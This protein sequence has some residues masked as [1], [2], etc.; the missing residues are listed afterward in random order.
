MNNKRSKN[1]PACLTGMMGL[2]M[3]AQASAVTLTVD[4]TSDANPTACTA[5]PGDCSLRGAL[6]RAQDAGLQPGDDDIH[7]NIPMTD[8]NCNAGTGVCT[9][10]L[11]SQ[12]LTSMTTIA[13][14]GLTI[15]GYTQPGASANTLPA[16]Q[17]SNAQIRIQLQGSSWIFQLPITL[18]GF[19]FGNPVE[20]QRI[21]GFCCGTP[22]GSGRYEVEGNFFGLMADGLT[23]AATGSIIL[24]STPGGAGNIDGVRIGGSLPAQRNVFGSRVGFD[25]TQPAGVCLSLSGT[26]HTVQNNLIGTDRSGLL[27]RGCSMGVQF[28]GA[29]DILFGGTGE[30]RGNVVASHSG[31]GLLLNSLA[32]SNLPNR[33]IGNLIGVGVDG[34]TPLPNVSKPHGSDPVFYSTLRGDNS[35]SFYLIQDNLIGH[36]GLNR[37]LNSPPFAQTPAISSAGHWEL[38]GNRFLGNRGQP[39][40]LVTNATKHLP[41]D[42]GDADV[43]PL[44]AAINRL[45]NFPTITAFSQA[46]NTVEV[47][48]AVDSAPAN[49]QY[50]LDIEFYRDNGQ[51][52]LLPIGQDVYTQAEAQTAV[53]ASFTLPAG[54]TLSEG[55]VIV[56]TATSAPNGSELLGETSEMSFYPVSLAYSSLPVNAK[57]GAPATIQVRVTA[58][59]GPYPPHGTV[60]LILHSSPQATCELT[61]TPGPGAFESTGECILIPPQQGNLPLDAYYNAPIRSFAAADGSSIVV[62]TA[63]PVAAP[64]PE[65]ISFAACRTIALEGRD[66]LVRIARPSGATANVSV[67]LEHIIGTATAGT[68]YTAPATQTLSWAAGEMAAKVVTIPIASDGLVESVETFRL[69][70]SN[71]VNTA[72]LPNSL[73]EVSILDGDL[74]GFRD[75]FEGDCPL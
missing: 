58:L 7:F 55:Q 12:I 11:G 48:Y 66:L 21:G 61:L 8:A 28:S 63:L 14:G 71:P 20:I 43:H 68:D 3:A 23:P 57:A 73:M 37:P 51:G 18:R 2:L 40:M 35:P 42:A 60:M 41:N 15:D 70:L 59:A 54:V 6:T 64:G 72:I 47:T 4:T 26:R 62:R 9:I 34:T 52:E 33:I 10:A 25:V 30:G 36:S 29:A 19:A 39:N 16:S 49:S 27:P 56:A 32:A 17:G 13:Q 69:R 5:A 31:E 22:P 38:R 46:G 65:Q 1:V 53:T 24:L 44:N 50:P 75:G 45:Q 74:Q 67:T